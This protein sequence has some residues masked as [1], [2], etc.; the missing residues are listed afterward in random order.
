MQISITEPLIRRA[1]GVCR[2]AD[3]EIYRKNRVHSDVTISCGMMLLK[4]PISYIM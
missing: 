3:E 2:M 4:T 1:D